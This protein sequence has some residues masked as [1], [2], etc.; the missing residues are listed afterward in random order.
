MRGPENPRH[1]TAAYDTNVGG[2]RCATN[3]TAA[4]GPP[5]PW[6]CFCSAGVAGR[7][8]ITAATPTAAPPFCAP[9]LPAAPRRSVCTCRVRPRS[10]W[11][12]PPKAA[13]QVGPRSRSAPAEAPRRPGARR[14]RA[15]AHTG[16]SASSC[17]PPAVRLHLAAA[18]TTFV[19]TSRRL[20]AM[21][22]GATSRVSAARGELR[23]APD[24]R[25]SVCH[26]VAAMFGNGVLADSLGSPKPLNEVT[27][28]ASHR[29]SR[30]RSWRSPDFT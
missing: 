30:M 7:W 2:H 11:P 21:S 16:R 1:G 10:A 12:F 20:V 3:D 19:A 8:P 27:P 24:H 26:A 23:L 5:W 17:P 4:Y 6:Q 22:T 14:R 28:I 9:R 13:H 29:F 15:A 25:R 18:S